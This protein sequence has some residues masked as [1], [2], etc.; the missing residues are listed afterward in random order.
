[1]KLK[2]GKEY[3]DITLNDKFDILNIEDPKTNIS[4]ETFKEKLLTFLEGKTLNL[5]TIGVILADKTR[6]CDYKRCLPILINSLKSFGTNDKN[7]TFYI[8]YGTH[9]KQKDNESLQLYGNTFNNYKFI[10]HDCNNREDFYFLGKTSKGTEIAYRKDFFDSTFKI[11]FGALSHHYFAGFGGGR[12]LI[13][14]G[15]GY[16]DSI[17]NNHSLFLDKKDTTLQINCQPGLLKN[18]PLADDLREATSKIDVDLSIHGIL[19]SKG[20]VSDLILG[21]NYI[22]FENACEIYKKTKAFKVDKKYDLVIGS[23]GGYPKDINLIQMH[24]S[25]HYASMFVKDGGELY[26]IGECR[27]Q[28][29]SKTFLPWFK[30][31][32]FEKSFKKLSDQYSGN[33]GTALSLMTKLSRISIY[34]ITDLSDDTCRKIGVIKSNTTE[35]NNLDINEKE[36]LI[37]PNASMTVKD[38]T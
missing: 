33:G 36:T 24:K 19:N 22:D 3:V 38:I 15:L 26:L 23:S 8:A 9:S 17:Y 12:K 1:M 21:E 29:G 34:L 20:A 5:D 27:D 6:A 14:P 13:F 16:R 25:I 31:N 18:N 4:D 32:S 11:T 35:L 2:Y 10:H 37:I 28:V 7:I 30:E